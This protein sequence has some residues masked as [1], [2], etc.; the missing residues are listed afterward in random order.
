MSRFR[1][2]PVEVEAVQ[3][4]KHNARTLAAWAGGDMVVWHGG[5]LAYIMIPT[6]EGKMRAN[7]GDWII[8]GVEGEFYPC[9]DSVFQET[10]E[11]V[12]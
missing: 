3:L 12:G 9:K 10:Y 2:R 6:L 4:D 8:Q 7:R 11:R 1:K 5:D